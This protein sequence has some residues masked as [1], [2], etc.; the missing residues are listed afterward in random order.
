M[1]KKPFKIEALFF[2]LAKNVH[3]INNFI[4]KRIHSTQT[5]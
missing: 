5:T 2:V 1:I 3:L 4:S